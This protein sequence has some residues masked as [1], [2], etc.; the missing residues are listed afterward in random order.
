MWFIQYINKN[1][2]LG[3]SWDCGFSYSNSSGNSGSG[4]NGKA[5]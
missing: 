4:G 3:S 2:D 1:L 5:I